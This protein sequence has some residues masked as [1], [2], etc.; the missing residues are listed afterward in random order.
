MF[1]MEGLIVAVSALICPERLQARYVFY[2]AIFES[3]LGPS[4]SCVGRY[5]MCSNLT[6]FADR[7]LHR[8]PISTNIG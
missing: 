8:F 4:E 1:P 2:L 7:V 6:R 5:S 3:R